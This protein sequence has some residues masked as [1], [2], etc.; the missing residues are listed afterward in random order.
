LPLHPLAVAPQSQ[1]PGQR[2]NG[3]IRIDESFL[4]G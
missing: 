1:S 3:H 2:Q 4:D